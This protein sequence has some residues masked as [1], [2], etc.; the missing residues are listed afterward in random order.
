MLQGKS[1]VIIMK[2]PFRMDKLLKTKSEDDF[3]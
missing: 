3:M 2:S 1:H